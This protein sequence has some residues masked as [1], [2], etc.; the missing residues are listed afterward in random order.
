MTRWRFQG[1][2]LCS[3]TKSSPPTSLHHQQVFTTNKLSLTDKSNPTFDEV[4]SFRPRDG[5]RG[6]AILRAVVAGWGRATPQPE[7]AGEPIPTSSLV[8]R[9][10]P[11][12]SAAEPP[13]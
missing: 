8:G 13:D 10:R 3:P 9:R 4:E 11:E 5:P 6:A 1:T 2:Q 12:L 7:R